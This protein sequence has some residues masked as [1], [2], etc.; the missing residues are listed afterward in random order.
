MGDAAFVR[1]FPALLGEAAQ[2]ARGGGGEG[3]SDPA[4]GR[5]DAA[6]GAVPGRRGALR[7]TDDRTSAGRAGSGTVPGAHGPQRRAGAGCGELRSTRRSREACLRCPCRARR[8]PPRSASGAPSGRH[9]CGSAPVCAM[10]PAACG[11]ATCR[12]GASGPD[13]VARWLRGGSTDPVLRRRH[14]RGLG[15]PMG[16]RRPDVAVAGAGRGHERAGAAQLGPPPAPGRP[17][18]APSPGRRL[19]PAWSPWRSSSRQDNEFR[20]SR[21]RGRRR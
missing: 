15:E 10:R 11:D 12:R 5:P 13:R 19:R 17:V 14:D 2:G 4:V 1:L 18:R 16:P 21:R 7:A 6:G 8:S 3:C 9:G 20:S